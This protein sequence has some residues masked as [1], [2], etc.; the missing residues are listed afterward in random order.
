MKYLA[1]GDS[2]TI[3]E[4]VAAEDNFPNQ[5]KAKMKNAVLPIEELK[6]VATT[7]WKT[8]DLVRAMEIEVVDNDYDFVTLLIGVNN[9]Y[10]NGKL[11][12]FKTHFAYI[13]DRAIHY[14]A[15][16]T[17]RVV[18]LS[19]PDWGWTPFNKDR[20]KSVISADINEYNKIIKSTADLYRCPYINITKST[21]EHAQDLTYLAKDQL[22]LSAKEYEIWAGLISETMKMNSF[23]P[24]II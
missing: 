24:V 15:G 16:K 10:N 8:Y 12:E 11:Q 9:Q 6:I 5:V 1:L 19:I 17:H 23:C 21:R 3:G 18:V 2:Y 7:G 14:A 4:L 22:H 13:L 20:D